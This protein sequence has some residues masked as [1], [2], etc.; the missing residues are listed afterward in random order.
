[1]QTTEPLMM[2]HRRDREL[3]KHIH[4]ELDRIEETGKTDPL[5]VE[6]AVDFIRT[7]ADRIRH[8]KD[9]RHE[10]NVR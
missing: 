9:E 8:G 5:F 2:E 7:Y 1:M 3:L 10:D 4:T 6:V